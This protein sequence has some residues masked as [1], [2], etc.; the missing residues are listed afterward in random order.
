[1]MARILQDKTFWTHFPT[2]GLAEC[3][4]RIIYLTGI[5]DLFPGS[6]TRFS[7]RLDFYGSS[8]FD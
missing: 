7:L 4:V 8:R 6:L 3:A 2:M 5:G 1:M